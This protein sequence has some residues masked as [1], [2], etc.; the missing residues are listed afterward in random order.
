M[1]V[2]AIIGTSVG[3]VWL[4]YFVTKLIC[5]PGS[6]L[7][8]LNGLSFN[9]FAF[10]IMGIFFIPLALGLIFGLIKAL[11][12]ITQWIVDGIDESEID[13]DLKEAQQELDKEFPGK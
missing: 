4:S 10:G 12:Y 1:L 8:N 3:Y 6:Y 11:I 9:T 7:D 2:I 5:P 13:F